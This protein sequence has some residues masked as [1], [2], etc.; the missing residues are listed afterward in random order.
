[1]VL[2]DTSV[3]SLALRRPSE[4]TPLPEVQELARLIRDSR[5]GLIGP[6]RQEILSGVRTAAQ[7]TKLRERLRFFRDLPATT[8]D[9]EQAAE[10]Y[11]ECRS[12]GIQGSSTDFLISAMA[13]RRKLAILT[14]DQDF[15][16]FAKVLPIALHAIS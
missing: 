16:Q 12:R 7:F 6:V 9:F 2:V 5:A 10:F 4:K 14:T 8:S 15:S 13:A 3:W 11:N 1:M